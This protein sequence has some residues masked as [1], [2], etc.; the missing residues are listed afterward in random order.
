[1]LLYINRKF[2]IWKL[3][4]LFCHKVE[5]NDILSL[6]CLARIKYASWYVYDIYRIIA[7]LRA[8]VPSAENIVK[9]IY[10]SHNIFPYNLQAT[11][12]SNQAFSDFHI[13]KIIHQFCFN[14]YFITPIRVKKVHLVVLKRYQYNY[15]RSLKI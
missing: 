8:T 12:L 11:L 6:F 15:L 10:Q 14:Q 13:C 7:Y 4:H 1:M 9:F 2:T 5:I 3:C